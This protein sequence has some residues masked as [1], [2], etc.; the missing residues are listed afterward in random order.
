MST[1]A[2]CPFAHDDA[3]YVLG[4]LSPAERL[5]FERHLATC[6]ECSRSV[7]SFAGMPGLLD[8]VEAEVLADP[9]A[10]PPLP[11]TLLPSLN[12]VVEVR[13]RR[14]TVAIAGLAAAAAAV[15]A[16]AVPMVVGDD[17]PPA[18]PSVSPPGT[19]SPAAEVETHA[20]APQGEVPIEATLGLE[21]VTWGTR[22][23]LTC[24][25]NKDA[26]GDKYAIGIELPDEVD[27]L[28]YVTTDDGRT[29]QVG[30]WRSVTGTTM[31]VPAATSAARD[32]L[33]SVEV[34]TT[35]GRVVLRLD[36]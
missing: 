26:M 30:S 35:D 27:Y 19:S 31:K 4:A 34:R 14:R 12:R 11:T 20:M 21:E 17:A 9:P 36:A 15:A 24:T 22:M 23:L 5:E 6:D 1:S 29:E 10:D 8:L 25:Y 18:S 2:G 3:A 16:L 7:R 28:M 33:A 32:D 13:R